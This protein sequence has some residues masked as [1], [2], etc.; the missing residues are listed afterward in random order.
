M[1]G[2]ES[3]GVVRVVIR[4]F[5]VGVVEEGRGEVRVS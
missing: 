5:I 1:V 3:G 2:V 4:G